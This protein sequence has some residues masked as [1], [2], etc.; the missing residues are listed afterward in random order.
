MSRRANRLIWEILGIVIILL[1]IFTL[2]FINDIE[3]WGYEVHLQHHKLPEATERIEMQS[4]LGRLNGNGNGLQFLS[5]MLIRSELSLEEL[6][7]FYADT[8]YGVIPVTS[9]QFESK[10]LSNGQKIAYDALDET[11]EFDEYYAVFFFRTGNTI[12]H[13][14]DI[15]GH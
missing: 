1:L 6:E 8:D 11:E 13:E 9:A 12:F 3:L 10:L 4:I 15:R 2:I 5:T 7:A 14:I